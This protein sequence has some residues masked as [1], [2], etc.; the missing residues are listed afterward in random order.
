V[1]IIHKDFHLNIRALH[2]SRTRGESLD[3]TQVS[4]ATRLVAEK[5]ESILYLGTTVLGSNF[6]IYGY[7]TAP[8]RSTDSVTASWATTT[9]ENILID[10]LKMIDDAVAD[11]MYGPYVLYVPYAVHTHMGGDFKANSD[12]SIMSRIL[13]VPGISAIKPTSDLTASNV[14]L[15]QMTSDVVDIV[16]GMQPTLVEWDSMGG[17]VMNFKVLAIMLPRVKSDY[18]L[19]SGI[20]HFS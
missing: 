5:I 7:A 3:T 11:N 13:E 8:N 6:P 17:F 12:K 16:D 2:A 20:V 15:V 19:Q 9:G 14:I 4:L 18:A 1:P 10:V